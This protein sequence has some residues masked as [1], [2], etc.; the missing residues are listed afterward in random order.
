[1]S[2]SLYSDSR[3]YDLVM[4]R[5][6]SG[7]MLDFYHRQVVSYGGPTLELACGTGRLTIPLAEAGA[8]VM[9]IDI[10]EHMLR[11]AEMKAR[12]R[13]VQVTF[14][15]GDMRDFNL[16]RQ[17]KLIL[18][19]AQS[20]SHLHAREEVEACFGCVRRHLA[21]GGGLVIELFNP[22]LALLAREAGR[23]YPVGDYEDE[24]TGERFILSEEVRYDSASQVNHISWHF[25]GDGAEREDLLSFEMRQFFPQEIDALLEYNG[26]MVERKYGGYDGEVFVDSSPKQLIV[27]T[28]R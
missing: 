2:N 22:S 23:R 27:C 14:S 26:F 1:M 5:F 25:L 19:P 20:L 12:E 4:G 7:G 13:D 8:D 9:G 11:T 16:G 3:L 10:S 18:I 17:F 15:C 6:A 28:A 24:L 21:V